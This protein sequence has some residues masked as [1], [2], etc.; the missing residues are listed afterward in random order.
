M[1]HDYG[2]G[3]Q[4]AS[5]HVEMSAEADV[6]ECHDI[7]DNIERD[8]FEEIKLHMVVHLDP[9]VTNDDNVNSFRTWL[10]CEIKTIDERLTIHDLRMVVG[11]THT[12]V[13]FDCVIPHNF[14]MT[15]QE[16]KTR[17]GS[18]ISSSYDN[19]FAVITIDTDFA[20]ISE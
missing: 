7:L 3:R 20:P 18:L 19:Y 9:I 2:P 5:V 15:P 12:N 8:F 16:L 10:N 11:K 4:F 6:L 17:I 1:V 13:I 14:N